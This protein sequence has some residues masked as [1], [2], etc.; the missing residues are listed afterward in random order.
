MMRSCSADA[1]CRSTYR[2]NTHAAL[3]MPNSIPSHVLVY[4]AADH[5]AGVPATVTRV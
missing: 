1:P 3:K 4:G 2:G 5:S